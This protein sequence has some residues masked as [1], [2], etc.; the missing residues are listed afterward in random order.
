MSQTPL[1]QPLPQPT[2]AM[3]EFFEKRTWEHIGRVRYCLDVLADVTEYAELLRERGQVH[4]LSKF[5]E[6]ERLGYI[7]I[8]E[9]YR[10]HRRGLPYEYPEG[11]KPLAE[12]ATR[13]HYHSNRHHVEFHA[14]PADMSDVDLIELVCDWTAVAQEYGEPNASAMSWA[15]KVLGSRWNFPVERQR[16]IFE[17]IQTL[18]GCLKIG[19]LR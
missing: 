17:M 5:E 19:R 16:F 11:I 12:A 2:P 10:H 4:D 15:Q 1:P 6:P 18:D 8:T 3:V 14:S 13:H 7:W 9:Y